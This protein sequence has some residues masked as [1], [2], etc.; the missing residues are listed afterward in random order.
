MST[1]DTKHELGLCDIYMANHARA[2]RILEEVV[3]EQTARL[4]PA[5]L[6]TLITTG[7]LA[8]IEVQSGELEAAGQALPRVIA[9]LAAL[10]GARAGPSAAAAG[11]DNGG[12]RIAGV[13][14]YFRSVLGLLR[15]KQ[16]RT[17]EAAALYR[18][19]LPVQAANAIGRRQR[20]LSP[21]SLESERCWRQCPCQKTRGRL[22]ALL[23]GEVDP[24]DLVETKALR[25]RKRA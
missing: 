9:G 15:H 1:L 18:A 23:R 21:S 8:E 2:R 25:K 5:H 20:R 3:A 10:A 6:D 22:A 17:A 16:G 13:V 4:G 7:N 19:V 14:L 12:D 11:A 24:R